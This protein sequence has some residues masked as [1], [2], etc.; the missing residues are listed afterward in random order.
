MN[1]YPESIYFR[2]TPI[3]YLFFK[4]GSNEKL[5]NFGKTNK[6]P[7]GGVWVLG[8]EFAIYICYAADSYNHM[9]SVYLYDE[10]CGDGF[11]ELKLALCEYLYTLHSTKTLNE[12]S[13][14]LGLDGERY[15]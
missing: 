14:E 5:A 7:C 11:Y 10:R 8:K 9:T 6:L 2:Q 12:I 3:Q 4:E 13:I 1:N 15:V